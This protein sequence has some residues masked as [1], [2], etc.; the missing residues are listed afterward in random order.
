M[1]RCSVSSRRLTQAEKDDLLLKAGRMPRI[2]P[3]R[4]TTPEP[5]AEPEQPEAAPSEE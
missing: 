2:R 5:S 4:A 3:Q 1:P